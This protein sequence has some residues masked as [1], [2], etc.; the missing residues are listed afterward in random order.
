MHISECDCVN[1][2]LTSK[3]DSFVCLTLPREMSTETREQFEGLILQLIGMQEFPIST[4]ISIQDNLLSLQMSPNRNS[5]LVLP[6]S[7]FNSV[8]ILSTKMVI[9]MIAGE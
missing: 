2:K 6:Q 9:G 7:H 8:G 3:I 5:Q 4:S 1:E